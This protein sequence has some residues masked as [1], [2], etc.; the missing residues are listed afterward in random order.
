MQPSELS[1]VAFRR[2][3]LFHRP[4]GVPGR[5]AVPGQRPPGGTARLPPRAG[6]NHRALPGA[7]LLLVRRGPRGD[8]T[9]LHA[10][11]TG[12]RCLKLVKVLALQALE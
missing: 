5:A 1:A 4:D 11:G 9:L 2:A 8:P 12:R 7:G 6:G 10:K 3:V